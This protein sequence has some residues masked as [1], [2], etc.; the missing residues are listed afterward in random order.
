MSLMTNIRIASLND[1]GLPATRERPNVGDMSLTPSRTEPEMYDQW[2]WAGDTLEW[3][4]LGSI[5]SFD[6]EKFMREQRV[7][8]V[9]SYFRER[10]E[11]SKWT[12]F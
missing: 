3:Q 1:K 6:E 8:N 9:K 7:K 2:I 11:A 12:T 5:P 10:K 4:K